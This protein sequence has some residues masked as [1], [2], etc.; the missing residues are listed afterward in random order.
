M[1]CGEDCGKWAHRTS[2]ELKFNESW[3]RRI[4]PQA[5]VDVCFAPESGQI[6]D[7]SARLLWADFVAEVAD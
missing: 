7:D 4:P 6:A 2:N 1:A 5:L 3:R